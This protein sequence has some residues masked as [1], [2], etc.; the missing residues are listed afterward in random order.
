MFDEAQFPEF[1]ASDDAI[2]RALNADWLL[3]TE[4]ASTNAA[5]DANSS[6]EA[7]GVYIT[8]RGVAVG[9]ASSNAAVNG[10]GN[11]QL[12]VTGD[13][14]AAQHARQEVRGPG[15]ISCALVAKEA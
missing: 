15:G 9:C 1:M 14:V 12:M 4:R 7:K 8:E 2:L 5:A 11:E 13:G 3:L 6:T 10:G